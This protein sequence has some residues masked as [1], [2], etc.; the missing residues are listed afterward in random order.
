MRDGV[1]AGK[2]DPP[3]LILVLK[4]E[5]KLKFFRGILL[6]RLVINSY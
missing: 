3:L 5:S 2:V 1:Y 6:D 4:H